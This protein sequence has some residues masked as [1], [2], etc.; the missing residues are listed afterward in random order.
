MNGEN[1]GRQPGPRH[2]QEHEQPPQQKHAHGVQENVV[3]V[4][5][6]WRE[7]PQVI[8]DPERRVRQWIV[9]RD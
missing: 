5:A 9:L 2:A 3:Q 8:L 4:V 7:P 1:G 6:E